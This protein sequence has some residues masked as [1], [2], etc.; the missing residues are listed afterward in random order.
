MSTNPRVKKPKYTP[1]KDLVN[2][3]MIFEGH[4]EDGTYAIRFSYEKQVSGFSYF[5]A[6]ER[7]GRSKGYYTQSVVVC[8]HL[9]HDNTQT[10][11]TYS[12]KDMG[13]EVVTETFDA[14]N[15]PLEPSQKEWIRELPSELKR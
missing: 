2:F 8:L 14:K 15:Q 9:L 6:S 5:G 7:K 1:P 13:W 3:R 4:L 11:T 10:R 12:F